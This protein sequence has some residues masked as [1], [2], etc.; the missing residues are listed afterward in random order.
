[1][2]IQQVDNLLLLIQLYYNFRL[3][4]I[5]TEML[6]NL[7]SIIN[8]SQDK[9]NVYEKSYYNFHVQFTVLINLYINIHISCFEHTIFKCLLCFYVFSIL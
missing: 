3:I 5:L 6:S 4:K 9:N 7:L 2:L 8:L 1:M